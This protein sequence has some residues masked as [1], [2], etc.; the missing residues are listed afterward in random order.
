VFDGEPSDLKKNELANNED[1][2]SN[3]RAKSCTLDYNNVDKKLCQI[4]HIADDEAHFH[5]K[6]SANLYNLDVHIC[7][8]VIIILI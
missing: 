1:G 7:P 4:L 5:M 3:K 2:P 6:Q 8:K